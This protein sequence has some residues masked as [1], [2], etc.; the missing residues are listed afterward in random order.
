MKMFEN[1][2]EKKVGQVTF[3]LKMILKCRNVRKK[4]WISSTW[5]YLMICM[6][7][8]QLQIDIGWEPNQWE[9]IVKHYEIRWPKHLGLS[10]HLFSVE[11]LFMTCTLGGEGRIKAIFVFNFSSSQT[12]TLI[13]QLKIPFEP[14][15]AH[16]AWKMMNHTLITN[17]E[18]GTKCVS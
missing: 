2:L 17:R 15:N 14:K 12:T 13:F 18:G 9:L 7:I 1:C 8:A 6:D 3:E 4:W 10:L 16:L 5:I 11:C